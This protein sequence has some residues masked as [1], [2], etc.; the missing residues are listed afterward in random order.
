MSFIS[1]VVLQ[2]V[3]GTVGVIAALLIAHRLKLGVSVVPVG[4]LPAA[5]VLAVW[6][7]RT[8]DVPELYAYVGVPLSL[9]PGLRGLFELL[10]A[11]KNRA[12]KG[13]MSL[14]DEQQRR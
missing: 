5:A 10:K 12:P 9:A 13:P 7:V 14:L 6:L 3:L 1:I 11:L 4:L 8:P 2:A